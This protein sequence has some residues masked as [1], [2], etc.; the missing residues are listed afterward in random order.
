MQLGILSYLL[1]A[2]EAS[3]KD[4]V[5]FSMG[6]SVFFTYFPFMIHVLWPQ[7][8]KLSKKLLKITVRTPL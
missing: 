8:G 6:V 7:H 4:L 1:D 2:F 3:A 5:S